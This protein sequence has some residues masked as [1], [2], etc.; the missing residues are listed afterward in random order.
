MSFIY[1][2]AG[3]AGEYAKLALNHY[4]GCPGGCLYCFGPAFCH[5]SPEQFHGHPYPRKGVLEGLAKELPAFSG[6]DD[7]ILMCFIADPY[8]DLDIGLELT[9]EVLKLMVEHDAPFA[10][11]T[12]QGDRA[13]RDFDLM[14]RARFC[15]FGV[16]LTVQD[17]GERIHWEPRCG[18]VVDRVRAIKDAHK[19]DILTW[20]SLEPIIH[21]GDT[22]R[23]LEQLADVVDEFK[24]GKLNYHPHEKTIDWPQARAD[25]LETIK[26]LGI[27][28]KIYI[29][30]SLRNL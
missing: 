26:R 3:K 17:E 27:E 22:I 16:T 1:R 15:K 9:R 12:K 23:F 7:P 11:L 29:K 10:I 25:I 28:S 20:V 30:E 13:P 6:T 4:V 19:D 18:T 14:R 21:P 8:Q 24:I 5:K 2:P